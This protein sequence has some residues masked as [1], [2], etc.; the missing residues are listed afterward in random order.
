[1][2]TAAEAFVSRHRDDIVI[3][4]PSDLRRDTAATALPTCLPATS[5]RG[6]SPPTDSEKEIASDARS[7]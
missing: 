2:K 1:M 3:V 6:P 4:R 5:P 7:D